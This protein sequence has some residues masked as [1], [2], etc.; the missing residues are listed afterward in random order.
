MT[1][2]KIVKMLSFDFGSSK[3][4]EFCCGPTNDH[5]VS[6]ASALEAH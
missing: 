5:A 6:L 2:V 4:L 3:L 1:F